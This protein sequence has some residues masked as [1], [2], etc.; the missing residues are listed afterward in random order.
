MVNISDKIEQD[1]GDELLWSEPI[2]YKG[3]T[4]Y[5]VTCKDIREFTANVYPLLYDPLRYPTEIS[6]LP[7]L[8]FLTDILNHAN[9]PVYLSQNIMLTHLYISLTSLLKL[10]LKEQK[11]EFIENN[12]RWIIK[13]CGEE[14]SVEVKAKDFELIR[15]IILHQN[16]VNY[17]DTFIH[18]DIRQW[19]EEQ[20]KADKTP[21]I[22]TG[23]YIEAYMIQLNINDLKEIKKVPLRQFNHIVDKFLTRENYVMR[24][25]AAMSGFVTFK[26]KIDHWLV[27]NKKNSIYD[28][29]F[30]ELK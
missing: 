3:I 14:K 9:D 17:D 8:Y 6:T 1:Y 4:L 10:V 16:G 21:P 2:N 7:R 24:T 22:T 29:Y 12:K 20:E 11:V 15:Q 26:D 18:E 5:P 28:K 25:T 23:D 27:T 13:V 19:I 30:K